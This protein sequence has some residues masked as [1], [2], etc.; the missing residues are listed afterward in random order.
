MRGAAPAVALALFMLAPC[1]PAL[2]QVLAVQPS[3]KLPAM[4]SKAELRACM[5][6]QDAMK[7]RESSVNA[8]IADHE[9]EAKA[10]QDFEKTLAD[11]RGQLHDRSSKEAVDTFN[12]ASSDF[13]LRL[14]AHQAE[15]KDIEREMSRDEEDRAQFNAGCAG[16]PVSPADKAAIEKERAQQASALPAPSR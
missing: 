2:A 10:L 6:R 4:L 5:Q 11:A 15:R 12:Q 7:A 13:N 8:R 14:A 1:R 16:R 9:R 3:G